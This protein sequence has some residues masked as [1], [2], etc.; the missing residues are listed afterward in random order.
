V[1]EWKELYTTLYNCYS[2][3]NICGSRPQSVI[4]NISIF[5]EMSDPKLLDTLKSLCKEMVRVIDFEESATVGRIVAKPGIDPL[6]DTS[7]NKERSI[8]VNIIA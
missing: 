7:K 3:G 4:A 1:P 2:L 5:K 6:I 8:Y